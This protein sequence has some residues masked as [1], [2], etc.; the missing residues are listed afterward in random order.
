MEHF[1]VQTCRV[2]VTTKLGQ[3]NLGHGIG[4]ACSYDI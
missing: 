3:G 1:R 2:L 4:N